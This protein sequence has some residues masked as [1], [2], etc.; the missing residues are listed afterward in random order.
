MQNNQVNG[1][2]ITSGDSSLVMTNTVSEGGIT[3]GNGSTTSR[4]NI[5]NASSWGISSSGSV[6]VTYN[7]VVGGANGVYLSS[8]VMR[9]NLIAN[10]SGIGLQI[11]GNSTV[12]SNTFTSNAG[13]T[14]KLVSA[15]S[16]SINGNNLEGNKGLYDIENLIPKTTLMMVQAMYNWWGTTSNATINAR[17]YDYYDG[18]FNLGQVL[19]APKATAPIQ[20]APAYI[21]NISITPPSPVGIQT[22][23]F[24]VFFS[25]S[26]LPEYPPL[27]EINGFRWTPVASMP[28]P[29]GDIAA[30]TANNGMIYV[31]GGSLSTVEEYNPDTDSWRR[32]ADMPTPRGGMAAV[33]ASNGK[34]YVIGGNAIVEEYDPATNTWRRVADLPTPRTGLAAV[35]TSNGKIYAI[36]GSGNGFLNTVEEYDPATN[37]W[38]SRAGM[39]QARG[40]LAATVARNGKIYAVGGYAGVQLNTVEEY[41]PATDTWL[42]KA[43]MLM[44]RHCGALVGANNGRIY[45]IAGS[46]GFGS[47]TST[48]EEYNPDLD[49]WRLFN[50]LITPRWQLAATVANNGN[51]FVLGGFDY[52]SALGSVERYILS[53]S[54]SSFYNPQWPSAS[55]HRAFLDISTLFPRETYALSI[56]SAFGQDGIQIAPN[57]AYTFTVDY[58]GAI[59]DTTPPQAPIVEACASSSQDTLSASWSA[60]DPDSSIT[61]YSYAIGTISG[62]SDVVNWTNTTNTSFLRSGLGLIGG[63]KYYISVKARNSG[64]LWS[65]SSTPPGVEAGS[66]KCTSTVKFIFLPLVRR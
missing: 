20:V 24:D 9:G 28:T 46:N 25:R 40:S 23:D 56:S 27:M 43:S 55:Q 34:I 51:I 45:A 11:N 52:S 35:A 39:H 58:A 42:Y 18:D 5:Q 64:G 3:I 31:I 12:I 37:T 48:V 32:V 65:S 53:S 4:N 61:M 63:Q 30:V 2:S 54:L 57:I 21:R 17:I 47:I 44:P 59:G 6:T 49:T 10:N 33:T 41:N 7:R 50:N 8:G 36:G 13:N 60:N 38:R 62:G 1:G 26:M 29:R 15:T 66:S 14:I 16:L 19:Y 22:V